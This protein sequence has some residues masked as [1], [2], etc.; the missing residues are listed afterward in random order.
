MDITVRVLCSCVLSLIPTDAGGAY[1]LAPEIQKELQL[2][3]GCVVDR[4][5]SLWGDVCRFTPSG[6]PRLRDVHDRGAIVRQEENVPLGDQ[7]LVTP[8]AVSWREAR[9]AHGLEIFKHRYCNHPHHPVKQE[10][11]NDGG[12]GA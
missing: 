1:A 6:G 11:S 2:R 9:L 12:I 5:R 3:N 7:R 4:G 10:I 8:Y